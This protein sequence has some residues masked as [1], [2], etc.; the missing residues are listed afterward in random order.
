[1]SITIRSETPLD[2]A[3]IERLTAA[4]FRAAP[5]TSHTEHFIVNALR[6]A[7]RLSISLVAE[8]D[9]EIVGHV[10]ISPVSISDGSDGWYG[11]GPISV[12]PE[13]QRQGIGGR[14]MIQT[15][16]ALR[17]LDASGCVVLG[18]PDFYHRFGFKTEP[19]LVLPDVPPEYFQTVTLQ[20]P[21]PSGTVSY[22]EAFLAVE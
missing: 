21:V 14:L 16:A 19:S 15:M 12:A 4:A 13:R 8:D 11:L 10:A 9:G 7:D 18:D 20:G 2:A 6:R 3:A 5:H 17:R 22:H 1:M